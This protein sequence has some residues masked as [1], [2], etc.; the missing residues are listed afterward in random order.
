MEGEAA[1]IR[2]SSVRRVSF[3]TRISYHPGVFG[4]KNVMRHAVGVS[5]IT[6]AFCHDTQ[7]CVGW[8]IGACTDFTHGSPGAT[9]S[10]RVLPMI[11]AA[12]P[13][14]TWYVS[15]FGAATTQ[16]VCSVRPV[17]DERESSVVSVFSRRNVFVA[18]A[19]IAEAS[20]GGHRFGSATRHVT[21]FLPDRRTSMAVGTLDDGAVAR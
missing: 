10:Q 20:G 3:A 4:S 2:M 8:W 16:R 15:R 9:L 1:C 7:N 17:P 21:G 5:A 13:P 11:T 12:E 18:R 6:W 14:R 19:T